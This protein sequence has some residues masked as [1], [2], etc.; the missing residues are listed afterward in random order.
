MSWPEYHLYVNT[1]APP[2][3]CLVRV[4]DGMA[5]RASAAALVQGDIRSLVLHFGTVSAGAW[6]AAGLGSGASIM[7]VGK[8]K[9]G[10]EP[11]FSAETFTYNSEA[12]TYTADLDL[13]TDNLDD[14]MTGDALLAAV[15]IEVSGSGKIASFQ[16][17]VMVL[18][19]IYTGEPPI[20]P[21]GPS[22]YTQAQVDALISSIISV[23]TGMRLRVTSDGQIIVEELSA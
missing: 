11:L 16:F 14:A 23:P 6:T 3:A 21:G 5:T 20:I 22:Y 10:G 15:D 12:K 2:A 19:E 9:A 18:K 13:H 4:A 7:V 8:P 1:G 17:D